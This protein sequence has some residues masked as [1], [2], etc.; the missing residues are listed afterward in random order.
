MDRTNWIVWP[1]TTPSAHN[2]VTVSIAHQDIT[3]QEEL[4]L[5]RALWATTVRRSHRL[6][7]QTQLPMLI[8]QAWEICAQL[9]PIAQPEWVSPYLAQMVT[10]NS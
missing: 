9:Q 3:A 6:Q 8:T 5:T 4:I 7:L 10:S 1:P 2:K